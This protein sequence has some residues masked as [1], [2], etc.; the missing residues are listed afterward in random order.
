MCSQGGKCIASIAL[1]GNLTTSVTVSEGCNKFIKAGENITIGF[2]GSGVGTCPLCPGDTLYSNKPVLTADRRYMCY[3]SASGVVNA[4]D[5][6]VIGIS[7][8]ATDA[9]IKVNVTLESDPFPEQITPTNR[10]SV[11]VGTQTLSSILSVSQ[12]GVTSN[13]AQSLT[14]LFNEV[15]EVLS[16]ATLLS[17]IK[18]NFDII[19]KPDVIISAGKKYTLLFPSTGPYRIVDSS[20]LPATVFSAKTLSV[21]GETWQFLTLG[22][23]NF[24]KIGIKPSLTHNVRVGDT[25]FNVSVTATDLFSTLNATT[26][27]AIV[28]TSATDVT[29]ERVTVTKVTPLHSWTCNVEDYNAGDGVCNCNVSNTIAFTT[30]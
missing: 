9:T 7:S 5:Q 22:S 8:F 28:Y 3:G 12:S 27:S 6:A 25:S 16:R 2:I 26:F 15:S 4:L 30:L 13:N 18:D 11:K 10:F 29:I 24:K 20:K 21:N 17:S 23:S 14:I 1:S 19:V